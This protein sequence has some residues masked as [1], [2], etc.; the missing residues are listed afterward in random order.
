MSFRYDINALRAVAVIGVLLFHFL[1]SF[2]PGGYAGV[3]VFFVISGFL[4]TSIIFRDTKTFSVLAFYMSRVSRIIPALLA[5]CIVLM[6]LG[7]FFLDPLELEDL[8]YHAAGSALFVS[9]IIYWREADYFDTAAHE[10]WLLHTWSL[11]VEWQFYLLY[12]IIIIALLRFFSRRATALALAGL[13]LASM[14]LS[15]VLAYVDPV[16]AFYL[17]PTRIW[18]MLAG[19]MVFLFGRPVAE[20]WKRPIIYTG[21]A[22]ITASYFLIDA[23]TPWPGPMALFPVL[24]T[25]AIILANKQGEPLFEN[26]VASWT[27]KT[28]YSIYLWHWPFVVAGNN[29]QLDTNPAYISGAVVASLVCAHLSYALIESKRGWHGAKPKSWLRALTSP[30]VVGAAAVAVAGI[31]IKSAGG[32]A[33][34][35][36]E[37]FYATLALQDRARVANGYCYKSF[38]LGP[39]EVA[40]DAGSCVLGAEGEPKALLIGDSYA[41][42]YEPYW[43]E[44]GE[45]RG[46]SIASATTNWCYP[47]FGDRYVERQVDAAREQCA[48]NRAHLASSAYETV[49]F[50]AAWAQLAERAMVEEVLGAAEILASRGTSVVLMPSPV[51]YDTDVNR[52]FRFALFNEIDFDVSQISRSKDEAVLEVHEQLERFAA[53]TPGVT[54]ISREDLYGGTEAYEYEGTSVPMS[55]DGRHISIGA[56]LALA[57]SDRLARR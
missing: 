27:G 28:S 38:G 32:V 2:A 39:V 15:F 1:P 26:P 25:A 56:A 45:R 51:Y 37:D 20:R 14:L 48:L 23:T 11:S 49:I 17:L 6:L 12:P 29:L 18:E 35:A 47:S 4:M 8:A 3:D 34:R 40:D 42:M 41:G 21:L 30:V 5:L 24:A 44:V 9:N 16:T 53:R 10:K 43:D 31:G 7:W 55:I 33:S 50:G 19:G 22:M 13:F 36:S 52:R 46:I 57:D 54:F